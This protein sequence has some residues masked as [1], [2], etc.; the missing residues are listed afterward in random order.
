MKA[1]SI[2]LA[3]GL[4][5]AFVIALWLSRQISGWNF[6][7]PIAFAAM[8]L[9]VGATA[10]LASYIPARRASRVDPMIVLREE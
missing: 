6:F 10:G 7:D 9:L 5:L 1:T 2:G 4:F 8:T 3:L